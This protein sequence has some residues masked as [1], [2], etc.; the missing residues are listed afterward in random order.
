MGYMSAVIDRRRTIGFHGD[1]FGDR[2]FVR[3]AGLAVSL[4][5]QAGMGRCATR[6]RAPKSGSILARRCG[7]DLPE[8]RKQPRKRDLGLGLIEK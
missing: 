4:P 5:A 2:G 1:P 8:S 6:K 7:P 3:L